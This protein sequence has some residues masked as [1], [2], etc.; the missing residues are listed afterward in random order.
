MHDYFNSESLNDHLNNQFVSV[1]LRTHHKYACVISLPAKINNNEA[2]KLI[3]ARIKLPIK[4][5]ILY[6]EGKRVD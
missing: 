3:S 5:L 2:I 4:H 1:F 6:Y